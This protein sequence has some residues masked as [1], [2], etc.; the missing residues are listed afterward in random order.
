MPFWARRKAF[1][2][3]WA[4]PAMSSSR[5][6]VRM[7][8]TASTVRTISRIRLTIERRAGL[9]AAAMLDRRQDRWLVALVRGSAAI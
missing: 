1:S 9:P 3:Y 8:E 4:L 5:L 2:R 7:V 6:A